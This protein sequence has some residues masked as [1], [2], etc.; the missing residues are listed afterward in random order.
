MLC[1]SPLTVVLWL[2][3]ADKAANKKPKENADMENLNDKRTVKAIL[4]DIAATH[5]LSE[6]F[7]MLLEAVTSQVESRR[8]RP[9]LQEQPIKHAARALRAA[10]PAIRRSE[11]HARV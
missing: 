7:R 8:G 9:T 6:T 2:N 1:N 5:G 11:R 3:Q 4:R 10:L